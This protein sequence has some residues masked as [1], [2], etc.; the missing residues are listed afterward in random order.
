MSDTVVRIII[1]ESGAPA[2]AA[3]VR[4]I[5]TGATEA[6]AGVDTLKSSMLQLQGA[7]AAAGLVLG[8][9]QILGL[10]EAYQNSIQKIRNNATS[11][12]DLAGKQEK[13]YAIALKSHQAFDDV[14][15]TFTG[16][17]KAVKAMGGTSEETMQIT[18]NLSKALTASGKTGEDVSGAMKRLGLAFATGKADGR[19]FQTLFMQFPELLN[20]VAKSMSGVNGDVGKLRAGLNDGSITAKQMLDAIKNLGGAGSELEQKFARVEVTMTQAWT[21]IG[22][23][24]EEYVGQTDQAWGV[25]S[26][27][28]AVLE[29]VANNLNLVMPIVSGLGV[30]ITLLGVKMIATSGAASGLMAA[31]GANKWALIAGAVVALAGLFGNF[32]GKIQILG[33]GISVLGALSAAFNGLLS[34]GQAV[35]T[36]LTS[37][38]AGFEVLIGIGATLAVVMGVTLVSSIGGT[39]VTAFTTLT[40][41]VRTLSAALISTLFNPIG[42]SVALFIAGAVAVAYYTGSLE[43]L[44]ASVGAAAA[45]IGSE[46][47]KSME[48]ASN[49]L[50]KN[51]IAQKEWQGTWKDTQHNVTSAAGQIK[52]DVGSMGDATKKAMSEGSIGI[53]MYW[54]EMTRSQQQTKATLQAMGQTTAAAATV[55]NEA[56]HHAADDPDAGLKAYEQRLLETEKAQDDFARAIGEK[57]HAAAQ[58]NVDALG[59]CKNAVGGYQGNVEAADAMTQKFGSTIASTSQSNAQWY[60]TWTTQAEHDLDDLMKKQ[61][62]AAAAARTGSGGGGGGGGGG[63][64]GGGTGE[65]TFVP[66]GWEGAFQ[67][68]QLLLKQI[69]QVEDQIK[70][71]DYASQKQQLNDQL[72]GINTATDQQLTQYETL[73]KQLQLK[74]MELNRA[75]DNNKAGVYYSPDPNIDQIQKSVDAPTYGFATGGS[76]KVGGN[77]GVDSQLVKFMATPGERVNI[78]TPGQQGGGGGAAPIAVHMNVY[79]TD[80]SGFART[81][82][83]RQIATQLESGLSRI[84]LGG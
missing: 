45:K 71:V 54:Q 72:H 68:Q 79:A 4:A 22:T 37:T 38:Q 77:G 59:R 47:K 69:Q 21:D 66:P 52:T 2:A 39:L 48:D 31:I 41:V 78:Q 80:A 27:L 81:R 50:N 3:S 65:F 23:A 57:T 53:Q 30:A 9:Q 19:T 10:S 24:L 13:L 64:A 76:F 70:Q 25:T 33:S 58:T 51:G 60:D 28:A 16:M 74:E 17:D 61:D 43:K 49:E 36:W 55:I 82:T 14:T 1:S 56:W 29:F 7:L 12:E 84:R 5:G 42:A 73:Q 11:V 18:E 67:Q 20:L 83:Q 34:V 15:K 8:I 46:L 32:L 44:T 40:A 62:E 75:L 6:A 26:K 63:G 35:L